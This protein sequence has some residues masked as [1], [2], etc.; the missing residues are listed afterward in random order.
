M[1]SIT[2]HSP[3]GEVSIS[4]RERAWMGIICNDFRKMQMGLTQF[5]DLDW[6]EHVFMPGHYIHNDAVAMRRAGTDAERAD[7]KWRLSKSIDTYFHVGDTGPVVLDGKPVDLFCLTLNSALQWGNPAV[8]LAAKLHGQCEIHCYVEGEDRAW[9]ADLV[10]KAVEAGVFRPEPSGYD[11]WEKL[12]E[13]LRS[14]EAE[15]VVTS[16]SVTDTFPNPSFAPDGLDLDQDDPWEAWS[17]IE[18]AKQWEYGM[19]KLRAEPGL[20]L[21]PERLGN[22]FGDGM[23]AR[24]FMRRAKAIAE[25][26]QREAA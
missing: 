6:V 5:G 7:I 3:R 8:Q 13:F 14:T 1:S 12:A 23:A 20:Q 22:R 25:E 11:G 9:L 4:G 16:Y 21:S 18:T 2:F 19:A 24:E 17:R 26:K 10:E 15:P